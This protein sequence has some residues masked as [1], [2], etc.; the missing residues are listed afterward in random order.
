MS[1]S[2]EQFFL[3]HVIPHLSFLVKIRVIIMLQRILIDDNSMT[4]QCGGKYLMIIE[5]VLS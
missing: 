3:H 5:V 1:S 4:I 2:L